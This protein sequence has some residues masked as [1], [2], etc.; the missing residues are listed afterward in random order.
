MQITLC[1]L[2]NKKNNLIIKYFCISF[3]ILLFT[4]LM[5][6]CMS[7]AQDS[8]SAK[9]DG[10]AGAYGTV[11]LPRSAK[12]NVQLGLAYLEQGD[13]ERAKDKF[14]KALKQAPRMPEGHYNLAHFYYLID[15]YDLA[16]KHFNQAIDYSNDSGNSAGVLG[17]ARNNYGVFLCQ[18]KKYQK[19][20]EQFLLAIEDESYVDTASA[21]EN[22]GLCALKS[23]DKSLAQ[24]Y[25]DKAI[26]QN[27]LSAKALIELSE[28]NLADKN[29]SKAK[30][31]LQRYNQANKPSR[32]SLL[33]NLKLATMLG[34]KT[35][36][37]SITASINEKFPDM[38]LEARETRE[39]KKEISGLTKDS[40]KS[41]KIAD[42]NVE[43]N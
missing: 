11:N 35:E 27:P 30:M 39:F 7:P 4:I 31:Y 28:F 12:Y 20:Q 37:E 29:Y 18:I 38:R 6:G 3:V 25:F 8:K 22:A 34:D 42:K 19:A 43:F 33:L 14:L 23:N 13:V 41:V 2:D 24:N 1:N 32:R 40:V 9:S 10:E 21:Y 17:T 5:Q 15:E 16:D 36:I 26:K